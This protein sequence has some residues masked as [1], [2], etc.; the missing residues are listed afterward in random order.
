MTLPGQLDWDGRR[1]GIVPENIAKN[2]VKHF[3]LDGF[4]DEVL[5]ALLQRGE[6]VLLIANG[7]NHDDAGV[8]M[9]ADDALDG[10]DAL[11][12]RHGDVHEDNIG[13]GAVELGNGGQTVT[14]FTRYFAAEE[15][16]HLDEVLAGEDRVVHDQVAYGLLVFAK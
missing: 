12:L 7:R 14:G 2:F 15:L 11:H 4:L 16:D 1:I 9:L 3:G 8:A 13:V 5:G 6:N 10:L